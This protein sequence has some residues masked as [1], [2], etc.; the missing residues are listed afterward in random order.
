MNPKYIE[1]QREGNKLYVREDRLPWLAEVDVIVFDCDGVLLDVRESYGKA[2]AWIMSA[3]VEAFTGVKLPETLFDE[4]LSFAY[5]RTGGMNNDW[6]LTYALVMRVLASSPEAA[7]IE[8]LAQRSLG[9]ED[10]LQR[11]RFIEENRVEAGIPMDGLYE[12]LLSFAA[13]L[14]D[15]GVESVDAQLL[16]AMK[17]VKQALAHPGGVGESIVSTIFEEVFSGAALFEETFGVPARFTDA[18]TGYVENEM[19][20]VT[21]ETLDQLEEIIG[22]ARFGVA[23]GSLANTARHALGAALRRFRPEAQVWHDDIEQA[24]AA[25]GRRGLGKPNPYPLTRS[26]EPYQP[27]TRALYA[28]DTVADMLTAE[29]AGDRYLFAGVYGC[30]AASVEARQAFL[31]YGCDVVAHSVNDLPTIL[32][33]AR[34]EAP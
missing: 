20:V 32:R 27:I 12:E 30:V 18:Q 14:D 13:E 33:A 22:G 15:S 17:G 24:E 25:T 1:L 2:V 5:K 9:I 16:P 10:M 11:L 8:G 21:D 26:A 34:S 31:E 4:R 7:E 23:S 19:V 3:L 29:R 6:D 28:G